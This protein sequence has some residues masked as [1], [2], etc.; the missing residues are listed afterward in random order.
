MENLKADMSEIRPRK[1]ESID[2]VL[3][4]LKR[5]VHR[6]GIIKEVRAR[7]HYVKPS[8]KRKLQLKKSKFEQM[9][10]SRHEL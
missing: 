5:R 1:G 8:E 3:R 10:R 9:L 7:R 6:E 4:R 2:S